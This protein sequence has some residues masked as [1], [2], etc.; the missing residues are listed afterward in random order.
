MFNNK[1]FSYISILI[2]LFIFSGCSIK[3]YENKQVKY[4]CIINN[5]KA[6]DWACS[7]YKDD[8]RYFEV[9]SINSSKFNKDLGKNQFII[10]AKNRLTKKIQNDIKASVTNY[11]KST[12]KNNQEMIDTVSTL[13]WNQNGKDVFL[14]AGKVSIWE[15]KSNNTTYVFLNA[16]KAKILNKFDENIKIMV[17]DRFKIKNSEDALNNLIDY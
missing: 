14:D 6:P 17:D 9:T 2:T 16:Q 7:D 11:V 10:D 13:V 5:V 12:G 3:S 15:N 8:Y 4:E 1:T